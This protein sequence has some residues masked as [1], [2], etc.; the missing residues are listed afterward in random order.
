MNETSYRFMETGVVYNA[1]YALGG[2]CLIKKAADDIGL[3]ILTAR[4]CNGEI[5][6][7]HYAFF[8]LRKRS[9]HQTLNIPL[10]K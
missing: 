7:R 2:K 6:R 8:T 4:L 1:E 9:K 10:N 5:I 3:G